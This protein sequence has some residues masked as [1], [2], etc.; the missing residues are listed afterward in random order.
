MNI[1]PGIRK[2]SLATLQSCSLCKHCLNHT[3]R[4]SDCAAGNCL[5]CVCIK[6]VSLAPGRGRREGGSC[7]LA[8]VLSVCITYLWWIRHI[9][10]DY[11]KITK[12]RQ[13]SM[14]WDKDT[15]EWR[16][17]KNLMLLGNCVLLS[18]VV[19]NNPHSIITVAL[20]SSLR[21][22]LEHIL[23]S[24]SDPDTFKHLGSYFISA[25][26]GWWVAVLT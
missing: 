12:I 3:L 22:S 20:F 17:W 19:A 15:I 9:A 7:P 16:E 14:I 6:M 1:A 18:R 23:A 13:I 21:V 11:R 26:F 25:E 8:P 10:I 2:C 24:L 4:N 5:V